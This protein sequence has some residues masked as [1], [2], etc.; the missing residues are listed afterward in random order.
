MLGG[1]RSLG[2][3]GDLSAAESDPSI[4]CEA[5]SYVSEPHDPKLDLCLKPPLEALLGLSVLMGS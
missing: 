5:V 1:Q 2:L 4:L 3:G